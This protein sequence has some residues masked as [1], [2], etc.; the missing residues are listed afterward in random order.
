[1][2]NLHPW[3]IDGRFLDFI[4]HV[5]VPP[6]KI[7]PYLTTEDGLRQ[8]MGVSIGQVPNIVGASFFI[9]WEIDGIDA[10]KTKYGYLGTV[11][12]WQEERL[13]ALNWI[14]PHSGAM[15]RLSIQIQPSFAT[16]GEDSL[17]E[18][19][20]WLIHSGFPGNGIALHE[21]DG[22]HRHW[23]QHI[24]RLAALLENRPPKPAPYALA[25]LKFVG[26]APGIGLLVSGVA[27]DGPAAR[28][29]V[30]EGD[31]I[32]S[33]DGRELTALDDFHDWIDELAP[34][35]QGQLDLGDRV[36]SIVLGGTDEVRGGVKVRHGGKWERI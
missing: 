15:T 10:S 30:K 33:V 19:D 28:A 21:Y 6:S 2:A 36:V 25:G 1:M 29:G 22:H 5:N 16:Y 27:V 24:G 7:W 23:R 35:D 32:R 3:S 11:E 26:G 31:I 17:A 34:G 9:G 13:L 4:Q 18:S 20:I 14:L 8:W 12:R